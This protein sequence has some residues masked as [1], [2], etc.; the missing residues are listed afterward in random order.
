MSFYTL[1][2][3]SGLVKTPRRA[4]KKDLMEQEE[5]RFQC[6]YCWQNISMVLDLSVESQNFIEDCEVCC[7]P[8]EITYSVDDGAVM[9]FQAQ[10][11]QP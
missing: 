5:H 6:P 2:A 1:A 11:A 7:N 10:K 3:A 9:D 8:I 4:L